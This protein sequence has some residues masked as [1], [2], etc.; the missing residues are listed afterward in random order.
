MLGC[1]L[2]KELKKFNDSCSLSKAVRMSSK[3]PIITVN[4]TIT[5]LTQYVLSKEQPD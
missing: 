4:G 3:L 1:L 2:F 5:N